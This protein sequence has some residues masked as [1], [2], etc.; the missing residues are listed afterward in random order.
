MAEF[1]QGKIY[2]QEK[3][4]MMIVLQCIKIPR[5]ISAHADFSD[6]LQQK[7]SL[8]CPVFP[9]FLFHF[10]VPLVSCLLLLA[11]ESKLSFSAPVA[12]PYCSQYQWL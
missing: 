3:Q 2:E 8:P 1:K 11:R 7:G 10:P 12:P 9:F 4:K 5:I 6:V